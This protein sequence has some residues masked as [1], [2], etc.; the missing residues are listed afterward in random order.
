M[1]NVQ[2]YSV[3]QLSLSESSDV[4]EFKTFYLSIELTSYPL[5]IKSL[6]ILYDIHIVCK[7]SISS[8]GKLLTHQ[9]IDF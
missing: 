4:E 8:D 5:K 6:P 7:E 1:N 2:E 9:L 3:V